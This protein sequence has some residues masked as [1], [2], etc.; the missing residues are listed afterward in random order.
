MSKNN[1]PEV[2]RKSK[3]RVSRR[4]FIQGA[5][6]GGGVLGTGILEQQLF[7][8]LPA[9]GGKTVGPGPV[10]I[11]LSVNGKPHQLTVEPRVTLLDALRDKLDLTGAKPNCNHGTC[12]S[13]TVLVDGKAVYA[14][15]M[16]AVAAQGKSIQ[17]V[18]SIAADD[19]LVSAFVHQDGTQCG[20]CTP[21][22]VMTA[23]AFLKRRPH[24]SEQEVAAAFGGNICRCGTYVPIRK[25]VL[26]AARQGK[27]GRNA[28]I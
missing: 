20:F 3:A 24:P 25:A 8:K 2:L 9:A 28:R 14:C 11:T 15:S 12:G 27:G 17:T 7:G 6:A 4:G 26:E 1:L 21:G 18:E 13:C 10:S 23:A 5:G 19:A 22:F 16:L